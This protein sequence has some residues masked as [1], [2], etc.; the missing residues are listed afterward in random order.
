V[1]LPTV[2]ETVD[3][4]GAVGNCQIRQPL[5]K[6]E[7]SPLSN[8]K[9]EFSIENPDSEFLTQN[10]Y[11]CSTSTASSASPTA[12]NLK[13]ENRFPDLT[14]AVS[15]DK[16]NLYLRLTGLVRT[17]S[18]RFVG[19]APR[20]Y[21]AT[22]FAAT[23][24]LK[25][26]VFEHDEFLGRVAYGSGVGRYFTDTFCTATYLDTNWK[27]HSNKALQI[28]AGYKHLWNEN[29]TIKSSVIF[30][31]LRNY[32]CSALREK[33]STHITGTNPDIDAR[34]D[35]INKS[36]TSFHI[37]LSGNLT[38]NAELAVEYM[39]GKRRTEANRTGKLQRITCSCK[40]S[41]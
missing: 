11:A 19:G 21:N 2:G 25:Y 13:G 32:N 15:Y 9:F 41:F 27:L 17:N 4:G 36:L 29:H 31:Y 5:I 35:K 6:Y 20:T 8:T 1:D 7:T 28:F 34:V 18:V 12:E 10:L 3:A 22:G 37:N 24:N 40:I 23:L 38:S 39:F 14:T 30:G 16:D 33:I 26:K